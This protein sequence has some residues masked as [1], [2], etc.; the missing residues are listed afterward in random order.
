MKSD[1][2]YFTARSQSHEQSMSKV[3]GPLSLKKLGFEEK[4]RS[5]DKVVV[6]THFG[7]LENTRYL[8]PSYLRFLCDYIK[9]VGG[10]PSLA[11]SCGWGL[12]ENLS[13]THTEYSGR[14]NEE[15]YLSV[16]L[17]HGFT[18]ETMGA[19]ILML[20]GLEGTDYEIQKISGK[21]FNEV[22]VGGRLRE[23]DLLVLA[24]HFK[25]HSGSGFGGAI[26]NLGIGCVSKGG[27]VQAHMGKQFNYD[28]SKC[29]PDCEKCIDVCPTR[30]LSK[31]DD[32]ILI[33]DW[34]KCRYCY[35][36]KSLCDQGVIDIGSST[37]EEFITQL[38]D[39]AKGV[40]EYFGDNKIFYINY[41]IDITWQCDC[42]SSDVPFVPDIG[43]LSSLDP[44][45]LDQACVDMTHKSM[46]NPHSILSEVKNLPKNASNEWFSYIPRFDPKSGKLDLNV[47]GDVSKHWEIQLKVAEEL[48]LG[49]RNYNLIN[50]EIE[51][52]K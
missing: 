6:K 51:S 30:A 17:Q 21:R 2:Y 26:K 37:N 35:S 47:N 28:L 9:E 8:R 34:D 11:E 4:I 27:K 13:G 16:A 14:A 12:A 45:A 29:I 5:G 18:N 46:I 19:P 40:V 10:I 20:D 36:C 31:S 44:V 7:A 38:V 24:T 43:I 1:V 33:K 49:S 23:F 15:E 32:R 50:V 41:A 48:G 25:G 39:N 42:G 22:L 3:K 52:S